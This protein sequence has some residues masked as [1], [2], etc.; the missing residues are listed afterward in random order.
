MIDAAPEG[1]PP[2]FIM[3]WFFARKIKAA[4]R[5][6]ILFPEE[7]AFISPV[8]LLVKRSKQT[9]LAQVIDFLMAKPLH[10]HCSDNFFPT[11]HPEVADIVPAG[12]RLFWIG[13]EFIYENDLEQV[14]EIGWRGIYY[15]IRAHR[16][17]RMRLITV[18]GP[19]SSGKTSV[20]IKTLEG[21]C[22]RR[23]QGR[24]YQIRLPVHRRRRPLSGGGHPGAEG[25]VGGAPG[26]TAVSNIDRVLEWSAKRQLDLT[27]IESAGLC[28]RCSPHIRS[29]AVC[30]ID[31]VSGLNTPKKIGPMLKLA[32]AVVVTKGDIV[33]RP[34][35]KSLPTGCRAW[36]RAPKSSRSAAAPARARTPWRGCSSRPQCCRILRA[37]GCASPCRRRSVPTA[38]AKPG[39]ARNTRSASSA[40]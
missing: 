28:N 12:K 38:S 3:P 21:G 20:L 35:A 11:P 1:G 31:N 34:S 17:G 33:S 5:I 15:G 27:V 29:L 22:C 18:A 23:R 39:L 19:P 6:E 4:E 8:Q 14:K 9:E 40:S 7:G 13:W 26:R 24:G 10:Q 2:L 30:V 32:D 25:L 16:R 36:P 37:C